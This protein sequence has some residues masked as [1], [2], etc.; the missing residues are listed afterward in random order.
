[1]LGNAYS[2]IKALAKQKLYKQYGIQTSLIPT[3][4]K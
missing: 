2:N 4:P 3:H 1:M